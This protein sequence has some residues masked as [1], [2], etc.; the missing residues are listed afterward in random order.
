MTKRTI[1]FAAPDF[2]WLQR[3]AESQGIAVSELVRRIIG[4]ARKKGSPQ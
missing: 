4:A 3:E 2:V 1:S